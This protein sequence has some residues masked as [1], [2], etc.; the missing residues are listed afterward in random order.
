[1]LLV[2]THWLIQ[3]LIATYSSIVGGG[4]K[5]GF[6]SKNKNCLYTQAFSTVVW[7]VKS[8]YGFV[9]F[10]SCHLTPPT[11]GSKIAFLHY[12]SF[13]KSASNG[14]K[15]GIDLVHRIT[16]PT[17]KKLAQSD[18]RFNIFG[19]FLV[20]LGRFFQQKK[21]KSSKVL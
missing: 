12:K 19:S 10:L 13:L 11:R 15:F 20:F 3:R 14:L 6:L 5:H 4:L 8:E 17:V 18:C 21:P 16:R 9:F 1:M 7:Y 2:Y